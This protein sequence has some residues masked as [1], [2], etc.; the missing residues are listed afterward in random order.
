MKLETA[1]NGPKVG[2]LWLLLDDVGTTSRHQSGLQVVKRSSL[3]L[4][5]KDVRK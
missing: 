2:I 1:K 3:E 5:N 4:D